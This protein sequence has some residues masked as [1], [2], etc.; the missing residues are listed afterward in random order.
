MLLNDFNKQ[1]KSPITTLFYKYDAIG[2]TTI[3]LNY[4]SGQ[5]FPPTAKKVLLVPLENLNNEFLSIVP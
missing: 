3:P 5:E 1:W 4:V 2:K